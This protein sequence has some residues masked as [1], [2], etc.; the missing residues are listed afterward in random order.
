[1]YDFTATARSIHQSVNNPACPPVTGILPSKWVNA[2]HDEALIALEEFK[3]TPYEEKHNLFRAYAGTS[4]DFELHEAF[5][6]SEANPLE[7]LRAMDCARPVTLQISDINN[8]NDQ[9]SQLFALFREALDPSIAFFAN[10]FRVGL[11]IGTGGHTPFGIHADGIDKMLIH[12]PLFGA[13][14]TM[15]LQS[16]DE[17]YQA[18][19][20]RR[21][22]LDIANGINRMQ[23]Y[24]MR[25]GE[26]VFF[27]GDWFHVATYQSLSM[28]LILNIKK[29]TVQNLKSRI[30]AQI[31]CSPDVK[32]EVKRLCDCNSSDTRT[33]PINSKWL[34]D[35][36]ERTQMLMKSSAGF[37]PPR[38]K[39]CSAEGVVKKVESFPIYLNKA[40]SQHKIIAR[41]HILDVDHDRATETAI[42]KLNAG[43]A[44]QL[45]RLG[46][47]RRCCTNTGSSGNRVL[48]L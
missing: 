31:P 14:K 34:R 16:S 20:H 23:P 22:T 37:L 5:L 38:P 39:A 13:G 28:S 47:T 36:S 18:H 42:E 35:A 10:D 21:P 6:T 43:Q 44:I 32:A 33:E 45:G 46:Q 11:F 7:Q 19:S 41:G 9:L 25:R 8:W 30:E 48:H 40:D 4:L 15:H 27:R 2:L 26:F 12:V 29:T 24:E 17:F 1:M 3:N